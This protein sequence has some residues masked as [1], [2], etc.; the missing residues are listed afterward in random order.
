LRVDWAVPCR[1]AEA[2]GDGTANMLG[3]GIDTLWLPELPVAVAIFL[4][5][6]LAGPEDEFREETQLEVRVV[7]PEREET[8]A[9]SLG[10]STEEMPPLK[11]PGIEAGALVPAVIQWEASHHGLYTLEET[12]IIA[13]CRS[14]VPLFNTAGPARA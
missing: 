13:C 2:P 1:Y 14:S 3:A 6:R 11:V 9:L 12:A 5:L 8:Q 7:D 10:F 4:M